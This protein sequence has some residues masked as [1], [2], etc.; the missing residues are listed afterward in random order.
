MDHVITVVADLD[1]AVMAWQELGFTVKPGRLH[2]NGLLNA[3]IKFRSNTSVELMSVQGEPTDDI[4]REYAELLSHAEGGVYLALTGIKTADLATRLGEQDIQYNR[5]SGKNW[6]YITF[7]KRSDLAHVFFIDFHIQVND[8]KEMLTHK[9]STKGIES[10][11]ID[12]DDTVRHLLEGLGLMPVRLRSE[13]NLGAGKG[14]RTG[15]GNIIVVPGNNRQQRPR[16]K[17][18]SFGK[19]DNS[20]SLIIRY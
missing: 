7:P 15:A 1:S 9:N 17:A 10:V 12:G 8:S 14:Y 6:D 3:H 2:D 18:V 19:E 20:A 11:W 13:P 4:A 16:I 5:L